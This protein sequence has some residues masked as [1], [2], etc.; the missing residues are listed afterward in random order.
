MVITDMMMPVMDGPATIAALKQLD[1][2]VKV[3]AVSGLLDARKN[4]DLTG[5]GNAASLRKPFSADELLT[6]LNHTLRG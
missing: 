3:I 4:P 2:S 1:P 6:A 5:I